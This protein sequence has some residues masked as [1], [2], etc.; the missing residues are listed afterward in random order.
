MSQSKYVLSNILYDDIGLWVEFD[1][2]ISR[3]RCKL[4]GCRNSTHAF[5]GKCEI[6]I[7]CSTS[8]NCHRAFHV[9]P[10]IRQSSQIES[11]GTQSSNGVTEVDKFVILTRNKRTVQWNPN[12][13]QISSK[14]N[15]IESA[16]KQLVMIVN[17]DYEQR[18]EGIYALSPYT[19]RCTDVGLQT[20]VRRRVNTAVLFIHAIIKGKYNSAHLKSLIKINTAPRSIRNPEFIRIPPSKRDYGLYSPFNNAC[21]MFNFASLS[22][23]PSLPHHEFRSKL[24]KL[25]DNAFGHWATL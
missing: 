22:I 12:V 25:P 11:Q 15:V 10:I 16:Q 2:K 20:L 4:P 5:C 14:K 23:D 21:R 9:K 1:N 3:S 7:C 8:R 24:L 18:N 13:H 19:V 17:G 6:H